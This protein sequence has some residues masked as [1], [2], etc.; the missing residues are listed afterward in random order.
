MAYVATAPMSAQQQDDRPIVF[1]RHPVREWLLSG[2]RAEKL[3]V[4]EGLRSPWLAELEALASAQRVPIQRVPG[5]RLDSLTGTR[6]HQGVALI[7]GL[8]AYWALETLLEQAFAQ[9]PR[10]LLLVLDQIVDP[11]NV[12]AILRTAEAAGV[13]GVIVPK[14][15]AAPISPAVL[16]TSAGAA[17]HLAI[18]RATN[19][20]RALQTLKQAGFW[21]IGADQG[22]DRLLWEQDYSG[23]TAL[24]IGNE[25]KGI[26]P[27]VR[28]HCDALVRI[29]MRGQ[30]A[31]L[32]ASV[33]AA[34]L[35]Y[36]AL[37]DRWRQS[38][39]PYPAA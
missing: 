14:H 3:Y 35:L 23:P 29:P 24:V 34:V 17:V 2:R 28:R 4:R 36:A 13:Q 15:G 33:A 1:G 5:A 7:G 32:N 19:L 10:P 37:E 26:R 39:K 25:G 11:H 6:H 9:D 27:L 22:A 30:V 12:G 31:S 38:L 16:K 8:V 20:V 21:V 18:A